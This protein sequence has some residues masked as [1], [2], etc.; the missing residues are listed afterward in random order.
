[1]KRE[2]Y[3]TWGKWFRQSNSRVDRRRNSILD[4]KKK[5]NK[6]KYVKWVEAVTTVAEEKISWKRMLI[7]IMECQVALRAR[8]LQYECE[9]K[10]GVFLG[11]TSYHL[12]II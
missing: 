9:F 4:T 3:A 12:V 8:W 11:I 7:L 2:L 5:V 1:M 10:I 6:T